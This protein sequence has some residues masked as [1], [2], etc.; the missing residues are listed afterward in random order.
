MK[1][2]ILT[3]IISALMA[4][5]LLA[6]TATAYVVG[7]VRSSQYAT[8]YGNAVINYRCIAAHTSDVADTTNLGSPGQATN[9]RT[10]WEPMSLYRLREDL[11]RI[12]LLITWVK[13]GFKV[14][15]ASLKNAGH[16]G[17]TIG[18][19]GYQATASGN[20]NSFFLLGVGK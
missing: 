10:Y 13:D 14:K 4:L 7:D 18:A 1:R 5:T 3:I 11:T 19:M 17:V 2:S 12:P 16:D 15:N 20:R 9:W 8:Y 6:A